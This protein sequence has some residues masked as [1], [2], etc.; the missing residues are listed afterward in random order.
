MRRFV[1]PGRLVLIGLVAAGV[2][3]LVLYLVPSGDYILLP[4]RAR[5]VAPLVTVPRARERRGPDP[6]GIYFLAVTVRKASLLERLAPWLR[7]GSTIVPPSALTTPGVSERAQQRIDERDM[8]QSQ[9]IAAALALKKLGFQVIEKRNGV[10]VSAV[11]ARAPAVGKL[12]PTDVIVSLDGQRVRSPLA[13]RR[14]MSRRQPGDVVRIGVRSAHGLRTVTIRTIADPHDRRR[15]LIGILIGQAAQIKLPFRV[16]I[17]PG[18]V[19]G[20]SAG[21][22][23]ALEVMEKLG[24]DVDRGYRVAATGALDLDGHVEPIGGVKQKAVEA[25]QS[26]VDILLVPAGENAADARR[27]AEGV[28]VLPV[29][30]FEQ[31]LR[32]LKT[33]PRTR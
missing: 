8:S 6:G 3:A 12:K 10:L 21:L 22:A 9:D 27:Y 24:R 16:S 11:D 30:T 19:V 25:K 26:D 2:L 33:L 13:L 4:D 31:A 20:P 23:F 1:G 29:H 17:D 28:R 18:S 7:D 15:A 14:L 5:A 32:V